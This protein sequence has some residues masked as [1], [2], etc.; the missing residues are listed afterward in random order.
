MPWAKNEKAG[1]PARPVAR[2]ALRLLR[3]FVQGEARSTG[4]VP[5][6]FLTRFFDTRSAAAAKLPSA[7]A[8][9]STGRLD[10]SSKHKGP[11]HSWLIGP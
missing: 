4:L 5:G 3:S 6:H 11:I 10:I 7:N 1:S 2:L 8:N 9:G